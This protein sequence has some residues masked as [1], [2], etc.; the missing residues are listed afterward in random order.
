MQERAMGWQAGRCVAN[1]L[2][3]Y[4]TL[5]RTHDV[6]GAI[7][8]GVWTC[9]QGV[10][11]YYSNAVTLDRSDAVVQTRVLRD[12]EVDLARP[13]SVKDSFAVLDL[14]PLGLRPLF[15][16][17]WIWR[18]PSAVPPGHGPRHVEWRRVTGNEELER[19]EASWRDHGSPAS[20]RVFLPELLESGD[21]ALLAAHRGERI[22]AGCV[23]NRTRAVVGFSNFFADE[24][25]DADREHLMASA[26]GETMRFA[27]GMPVVGYERD[28]DL[29]RARRL[30]FDTV[31][32][33]RVW[34]A[35]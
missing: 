9:R 26:V 28:E 34:L 1:S 19:W 17:E 18:A 23:A 14:V 33:L 32:P 4:E 7:S 31:G 25:D 10:P 5:L 29:A 21:V 20:T 30:G 27:P 8:R 22:V 15:D 2:A 35:E 13:F 12:L 16:A 6:S 24:A 11:P 3:W